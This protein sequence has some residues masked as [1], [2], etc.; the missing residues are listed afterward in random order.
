MY[1]DPEEEDN[2]EEDWLNTKW[3]PMEDEHLQEKGSRVVPSVKGFMNEAPSS[4]RSG[5]KQF[6]S[7][8]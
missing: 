7:N 6:S 4:S 2:D 3:C 8:V 5:N 1:E